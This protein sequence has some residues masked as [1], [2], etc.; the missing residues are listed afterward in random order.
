MFRVGAKE[1]GIEIIFICKPDVP[2][3]LVLDE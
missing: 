3:Q 2:L 1:K